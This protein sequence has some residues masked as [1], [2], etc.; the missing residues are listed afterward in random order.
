MKQLLWVEIRR[1]PAKWWCGLSLTVIVAYLLVSH[2]QWVGVWPQASMAAQVGAGL[3]SPLMTAAA[4]WVGFQ[5][6]KSQM[7]PQTTASARNPWERE[8][9]PLLA[10]LAWAFV[11]I[12]VGFLAMA[13]V[14]YGATSSGHLWP[15]FLWLA[16]VTTLIGVSAGYFLGRCLP[17]PFT[18]AAA[19]L[20]MFMVLF[21]GETNERLA[22]LTYYGY[23]DET[24]SWPALAA[25]VGLAV[26]LLLLALSVGAMRDWA[27][28][29]S[30]SP[31]T[32]WKVVT[33]LVVVMAVGVYVAGP[34]QT[35]RY[36][37]GQVVCTDTY[38]VACLWPEH[39]KYLPLV[40]EYVERFNEL[41]EFLVLPD[42]PYKGIDE[43]WEAGT[44]NP[45][46]QLT[47]FGGEFGTASSMVE[48]AIGATDFPG[49]HVDSDHAEYETLA[50]A[51]WQLVDWFTLYI[52]DV[53]SLSTLDVFVPGI[54]ALEPVLQ[55]PIE[56]QFAWARAT[57]A[58]MKAPCDG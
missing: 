21:L 51:Y 10:V 41:D 52:M 53:D 50:E 24:V 38:P 19:A 9:L 4:A 39:E 40:S 44:R 27:A 11:P 37:Y 30:L 54:D 29:R 18:V 42:D 2:Q 25:R 46:D 13:V 22:L 47:M 55:L 28:T 58:Q 33:G 57:V 56:E 14:N 1:S 7:G 49:C 34:L 20:I 23:P 35:E 3:A 31:A 12:V 15:T 48:Y 45:N 6:S 32:G 26:S 5:R 8:S 16:L 17:S 43:F 36:F